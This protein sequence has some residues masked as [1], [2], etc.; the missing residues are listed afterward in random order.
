MTTS[1]THAQRMHRQRV[2]DLQ[3][4]LAFEN[5]RFG[6]E[7]VVLEQDE[8]ILDA[9]RATGTPAR[10]AWRNRHFL[11]QL[12]MEERP[13][14]RQHWRLSINRTSLREDGRWAGDISW[15]ELMA[16]KAGVGYGDMWAIELFPPDDEVVNVANM[17]HL[18]LVS[19][20]PLEAWTKA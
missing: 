13:G 20:R 17:R 6:E 16:V 12:F 15:D 7:F 1:T 10:K 5:R 18:W 3:Q 14:G 11:V 8:R 19:E 4:V 9:Q 2:R